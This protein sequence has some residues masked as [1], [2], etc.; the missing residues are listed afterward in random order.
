M[1]QKRPVNWEDIAKYFQEHGLRATLT[2]FDNEFKHYSGINAKTLAL[3]RWKKDLTRER[4][5][6]KRVPIYGDKIDCDLLAELKTRLASGL[7][8]DE[9]Q[10]RQILVLLLSNENLSHLLLE[11]GGPYTFS[12]P[13]FQRFCKRHNFS[14]KVT[15]SKTD[16]LPDETFE[17]RYHH[18]I[19]TGSLLIGDFNIP[20]A[21]VVNSDESAFI[22]INS[23]S[24]TYAEK[25]S[26]RMKLNGVS[27]CLE[28]VQIVVTMGLTGVGDIL[29]PQ[30]IFQ[31]T[32]N[33]CHPAKGN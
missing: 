9:V 24:K 20:M 16:E 33:L 18:F 25:G 8:V 14:C 26:K 30:I 6:S 31:G 4:K 29:P 15:K 11:N 1:Y 28:K 2:S 27:A 7:V 32:T 13:W 22:L 12:H 19:D 21:L 17:A 23:K 5:S 3:Q 10:A